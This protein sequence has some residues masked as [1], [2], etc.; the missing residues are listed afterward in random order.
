MHVLPHNALLSWPPG[1]GVLGEAGES[2]ERGQGSA[3]A[4]WSGEGPSG[5]RFGWKTEG[6]GRETETETL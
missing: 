3:G 2:E 6:R 4:G 5:G 1:S